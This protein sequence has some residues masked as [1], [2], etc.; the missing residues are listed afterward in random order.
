MYATFPRLTARDLNGND[1]SLP[2]GLPGELN[3]VVVAFRRGQQKLVDS[4]LPWLEQQAAADARLRYVELPAI[5]W[6]WPSTG[7]AWRAWW[8]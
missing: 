2:V 5:G 7:P 4:W 6:R 8:C 1:V 3:V